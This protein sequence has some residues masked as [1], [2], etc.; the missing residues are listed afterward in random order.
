MAVVA[1]GVCYLSW[2]AALRRLPP[3]LA[4]IGTLLVPLV[5]V[6]TAALTLGEPLKAREPL[7]LTLRGVSLALQ[8]T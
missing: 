4:S 6:V 8:R 3:A 2:F 5:G 1:M 7:A